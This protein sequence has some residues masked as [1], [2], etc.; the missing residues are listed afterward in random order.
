MAIRL[1]VGNIPY[2]TTDN[3][4][5]ELFGQNGRRVTEV[6]II[7][8]RES[9]Q[10]RGYAFVQMATQE[11]A[12]AVVAELNGANVGGRAMVVNEA[13]ERTPG[14]RPEGGPRPRPPVG[15]GERRPGPGLG[16][17]GGGGGGYAPRGAVPGRPGAPGATPEKDSGRR[18]R[19]RDRDRERERKRDEDDE[20]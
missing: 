17:G 4:L 8:D 3:D 20:Y 18:G 1:Y 19:G 11:E 16:A 7:T 10:S 9:G 12:Q 14:P 13:R 5:R 2:S 6:K 15:G